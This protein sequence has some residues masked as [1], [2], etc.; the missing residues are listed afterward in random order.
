MK[1]RLKNFS[2]E[3]HEVN[4]FS[5]KCKKLIENKNKKQ[6]KNHNKNSST[7]RAGILEGGW[8]S[9]SAPILFHVFLGFSSELG[10]LVGWS[11]VVLEAGRA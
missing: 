1:K 5:S 9:S 3:V 11:G 2:N 8:E 7:S 6:F 10:V 4:D